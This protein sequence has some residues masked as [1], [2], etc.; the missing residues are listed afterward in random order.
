MS[1]LHDLGRILG[2][3]Y[4]VERELGA[5]G[6]GT[7]YLASDLRH[8]RKVAVKVLRPEIAVQV[9]RERFL[10]EIRIAAGLQ[11]PGILGL[12]DSGGE[13]ALL[14]Y[15]MPYVDGGTLRLRLLRDGELPLAEGVR[16]LRE[17][18]EALAY[19]H[20]RS[21]L[22]RDIK[23]ENV[24]FVAGHPL[25]ADFG[26]AKAA[27]EVEEQSAPD[28]LSPTTAVDALSTA[29]VVLGSPGYMAP[30]VLSGGDTADRRAD[31]YAFGV[32][33]YEVLTGRHPFA[34]AAGAELLRA[35]VGREPAPPRTLRPQLPAE[36][37]QL[38]SACLAKLPGDRPA[39]AE[40]VVRR[41]E[42]VAGAGIGGREHELTLQ[43]FKLTEAVCRQLQRSSFSPRMIGD[44]I[45]LLDN[46]V[47]SNVL[48]CFINAW[49]LDGTDFEPH[50]RSLPWRGIA[51]TLFG[52]EA[53]R[54][55]RF[56]LPLVDHLA[57]LRAVLR[58]AIERCAASTIL[59]VGFS[60]GADIALRLAVSAAAESQPRVD[61]VLTLGCN[62]A[63]ETCFVTRNLARLPDRD[64]V[65][66]ALSA[67]GAGFETLD[68][69]VV[70]N[71]YL[72]R[73][74]QRFQAEIEPLRALA[75]ELLQPFEDA[76]AAAFESI[77]RAVLDAG[78][79]LRCLFEDSEV[80]N[81]LLRDVQ[82]RNLD[83][84]VLGPAYREGTLL[85]EAD[86]SH[87]DLMQP[88]RVRRHLETMVDTL[89]SVANRR[90]VAT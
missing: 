90:T 54:Q 82:L 60:S 80:C 12:I 40:E 6:M 45:E 88:E 29:G 16:L 78:V 8:R 87:F 63:L 73:M 11:H 42:E 38:V 41:L 84:G 15:V 58:D 3:A 31:L 57:L 68:Q 72:V 61:G 53:A 25:L 55:R 74:L 4:V 10:R 48:V 64:R 69:W 9:G 43:R 14:Y 27:G 33:A 46:G 66:P 2:E 20:S 36:L 83:R 65:L 17:I 19:A 28:A 49:G 26:L 70:V 39:S 5:G 56:A 35:H 32:L 59:V 24:L 85:I 21:V 77:A 79:G 89:T 13:G 50:L 51:P 44:E 30:E 86:A 71:A 22:H 67:I 75:K 1:E 81:R 37:D 62:L 18:A 76:D 52:Y 23:P 47:R 7:V 34:G